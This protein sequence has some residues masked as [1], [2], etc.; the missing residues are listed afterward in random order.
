MTTI[1]TTVQSR[2]YLLLTVAIITSLVLLINA[3]FKIIVLYGFAFT[4]SSMLCPLISGLYLLVLKECN[5]VQQRRVLYQSILALYLF[6]VGIYILVNL[7][8]V[9]NI[10]ANIAYEI[11]FQEIPRKFFSSTLAFGLGFY[12]PF[13]CFR[14]KITASRHSPKTCLLLALLGGFFFFSI[15]FLLLFADPNAKDFLRIYVNSLIVSTSALLVIGLGYVLCLVLQKEL[16][17]VAVKLVA[18][19]YSNHAYQYLIGF[20]V[21]ILLI[22]LSCE[23][24]LISFSNGLVFVASSVLFPLCFVVSNVVGELY[25]YRANLRMTGILLLSEVVFNVI[26]LLIMA[27]PSPD[28]FD[29]NPYYT[30]IAPR[31]IPAATL[32][33]VLALGSNAFL[34]TR[35]KNTVYGR[36]ISLRVFIANIISNSLLCL[37]NYTI[38]FAGIYPYDLILHLALNSWT[39]KLIVTL[40]SLPLVFWLIKSIQR[41]AVLDE[42]QIITCPE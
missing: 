27:L 13:L 33:L 34:L 41:H 3:S 37:V 35:L 15:D 42:A 19:C 17:P 28:I 16:K 23:Y 1:P 39:Y 6:S 14:N 7:P 20:S 24:R 5:P 12:L 40:V 21:I 30:C 32:A 4:A 38:L 25:G 10:K 31:R 8:A 26:L 11:M 36:Y 9:E 29:I 22:C 18:S 2:N